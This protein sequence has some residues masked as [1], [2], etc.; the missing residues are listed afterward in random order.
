MST[1]RDWDRIIQ[2]WGTRTG[3]SKH[4][5]L[6]LACE[7]ETGPSSP[8]P[9][10]GCTRCATYVAGGDEED[11]DV[12]EE[13]VERLARET[14][15]ADRLE[16]AESAV[17]SWTEIGCH[18]PRPEILVELAR[19]VPGARRATGTDSRDTGDQCDPLPVTEARQTSI[20]DIVRRLGLGEP[21]GR[22]GEPRVL[23]PLHDDTDPSLRLRE[24]DGLWYCDPCAQGGDGIRLVE[25]A[26]ALEFQDA[27]C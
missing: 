7:G 16:R 20:R 22:G 5:K 3:L 27:V 18:L 9:G 8:I 24:A 17:A 12:A 26:L 21:A 23:C 19:R 6:A 15:P 14:C 25:E 2:S 11:A 4:L 1:Q 10:C 13:L